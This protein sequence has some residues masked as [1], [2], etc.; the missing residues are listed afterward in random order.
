MKKYTVRKLMPKPN[1]DFLR[2]LKRLDGGL[3]AKWDNREKCFVITERNRPVI[4]ANQLCDAVIETLYNRDSKRVDICE[5][6]EAHE[7][8]N[9]RALDKET[10][11]RLD[12]LARDTYDEFI[13]Y[14]RRRE[15]IPNKGCTYIFEKDRKKGL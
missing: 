14:E 10:D 2:R 4:L 11:D 7:E 8:S 12:C 6:V 13:R 5:A 15:F 3:S 9:E 1:Q